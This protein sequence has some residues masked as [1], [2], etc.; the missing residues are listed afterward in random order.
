MTLVDGWTVS[1]LQWWTVGRSDGRDV[2]MMDSRT[3]RRSG[4]GNFERLDGQAVAM[5][6]GW[7]IRQSGCGNGGQSDGRAVAMLDGRTVRLWQRWTVQRS[8]G[9]AVAMLD[10]KTVRRSDCRHMV[11]DLGEVS[12]A[13]TAGPC[14]P[15]APYCIRAFTRKNVGR[16]LHGR[17]HQKHGPNQIVSSILWNF[18]K[19]RL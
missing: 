1:L 2:A 17:S 8:D 12:L 6:D 14:Y 18:S 11:E 10:S 15:F 13:K 16:T 3:V 19:V 4:C 5:V 9:H 7:M